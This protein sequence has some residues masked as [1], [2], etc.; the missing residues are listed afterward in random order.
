[1]KAGWL[2][3]TIARRS[4]LGDQLD[5]PITKIKDRIREGYPPRIGRF[6]YALAQRLLQSSVASAFLAVHLAP[7]TM[8]LTSYRTQ[9][10]ADI[11]DEVEEPN[12]EPEL[13]VQTDDE[14]WTS[15]KV[16]DQIDLQQWDITQPHEGE[17]DST[18]YGV[19]YGRYSSDNQDETGCIS[20]VKTMLDLA[21]DME[22]P[23]YTNPIVDV[24]LTGTNTERGGLEEIVRL[25]QHPQVNYFFVH[26]V[27]RLARWNS[28][29]LF[30]IE[31]FTR[32]FDITVVTDEGVLDLDSLEGLATTWVQS[33]AGEIENRN[34]AKR[35]L[36]GQIEQFSKGNYESWFKRY[37][38]GYKPSE[39]KL[40]EKDEKEVEIAKAMF[41]TFDQA[42]EYGPYAETRDKINAQ[43]GEILD[44]K[45][46]H[47]P[48]K[49][50]LTDPLYIGKPTV[51]G[52]SIGDDG[53]KRVLERP[54]L[55]II[56]EDL[57]DSV[58]GK[59][60]RIEDRQSSSKQPGEV[61]ELE[62]IIHEF[63]LLPLIESSDDVVM[64]CHKCD[65]KMVRDG[66]DTVEDPEQRVII[67]K[68]PE[69]E[70]HPDRSGTYKTFP[71]SLE[72]YK[73]R[74]FSKILDNL[75]QISK[76][77]DLEDV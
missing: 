56:D 40:L 26:D 62:Y 38:I 74:L 63:G 39:E 35:T 46:K 4:T 20:R 24:A 5:C 30:L 47:D 14:P 18:E 1:M 16:L 64:H 61:L 49:Q 53:Q 21:E 10:F 36:G 34:K 59:I 67:F 33:M 60:D 50:M 58:N 41:R 77:I 19:I 25:V 70:D 57:F 37:K 45:L 7:A 52:K 76:V 32:N 43:Y 22:V 8:M 51:A 3:D 55:Q 6:I 71:N 54:E 9:T 75:D 65:A 72:F 12:D 2:I 27:D 15:N 11:F 68:C 13:D 48:L 23:L 17:F 31:V 29:C 44:E 42:G 69:C 73:I 66:T 28:F